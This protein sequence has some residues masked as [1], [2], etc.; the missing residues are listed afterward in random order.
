[1]GTDALRDVTAMATR[2]TT[3]G[4]LIGLFFFVSKCVGIR[5]S[6]ALCGREGTRRQR[7]YIPGS[8]T[9]KGLHWRLS[10]SS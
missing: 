2:V 10:F 5:L 6:F 4:A 7:L 1:M 8:R 3:G 9:F